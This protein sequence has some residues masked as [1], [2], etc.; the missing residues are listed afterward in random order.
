M[1]FLALLP[2]LLVLLDKYIET[3]R[4][5]LF[6][7]LLWVTINSFYYIAYM[8]CVFIVLFF[9]YRLSLSKGFA[10]SEKKGAFLL[11]KTAG[12]AGAALLSVGASA[13]YLVPTVLSANE[14]KGGLFLSD[15]LSL[16]TN[17]NPLGLFSKLG[18]G[19]FAWDNIVDGMPLLYCGALATVLVAVFFLSKEVPRREKVATGILFLALALFMW[20]DTLNLLW[21]GSSPPNW[22]PFRYAFVVCFF[23]V[24][25]AARGF[26]A[27]GGMTTKRFAVAAAIMTVVAAAG[28]LFSENIPSVKRTALTL[29]LFLFYLL[30]LWVLSGNLQKA[31]QGM[32][33]AAK[34]L[35]VGALCVEMM[36]N[37]HFTLSVFEYYSYSGYQEFVRNNRQTIEYVSAQDDGFYRMDKNYFRTLNDPMLLGYYGVSHFSPQADFHH[38]L[39]MRLGYAN[40]ASSNLYGAGSTAFAD[41]YLSVRYLLSNEG[42]ESQVGAHYQLLSADLPY[43]VYKNPYTMPVAFVTGP[44]VLDV[45]IEQGDTFLLQDDMLRAFTDSEQSYFAFYEAQTDYDYAAPTKT[46]NFTFEVTVDG[47]CYGVLDVENTDGLFV[48]VNNQKFIG[49]YPSTLFEGVVNLGYYAAG[50]TVTVRCI[51]YNEFAYV[52]GWT[53]CSLDEARFEAAVQD[54]NTR[55]LQD[56]V[57][58]NGY[59]SGR[60]EAQAGDIL[61]T[62]LLY[63]EGWVVTVNGQPA[64]T[65]TLFDCMLGIVLQS[66]INDIEMRYTVVGLKSGIAVSC[67]TAAV[68]AGCMVLSLKKRKKRA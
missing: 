56:A 41:A 64:E 65:V 45:D 68:F 40:Y 25:V 6:S 31:K 3:G 32:Q 62:T 4:W 11:K 7:V 34:V 54:I 12:M 1:K 29:A 9:F 30:A 16:Q 61:S 53:F 48:T 42:D 44:G 57:V 59:V 51:S 8:I 13:F 67:V 20:S 17:F 47:W 66:G 10:A 38:M 60:V 55:G 18:I 63:S 21:H 27:L 5:I 36:L 26:A 22:F 35:L 24:Y 37:A 2:A 19:S 33:K 46:A 52:T 23:I 15:M 58:E 50:D 14:K 43:T 49:T 28:Y 39:V